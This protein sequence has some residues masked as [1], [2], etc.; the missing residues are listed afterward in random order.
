VQRVTRLTSLVPCQN[1]SFAPCEFRRAPYR[2]AQDAA[3]EVAA[4]TGVPTV[5][6]SSSVLRPLDP[7]AKYIVNAR[8][9]HRW[10]GERLSLAPEPGGGIK[11][12]FRYD[13]TT[14]SN[15]GRPLIFHYHVT[16]GPREDGYPLR[17]MRC[18]PAPG[19]EGHRSMCLYLS[20][21][22]MLR[23][24]I[25]EEKPLL[26]KPLNKIIGWSRPVTGAGCYCEPGS[27][28]HKW[29]LALETIHFALLQR[30]NALRQS[31]KSTPAINEV[32][33][34]DSRPTTKE[35]P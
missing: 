11:A 8:A 25:E 13:G 14:C 5:Q 34:E 20:Q 33:P 32:P 26:G 1:C 29:G 31:D 28:Q 30:E 19:D 22:E 16:L 35:F 15:M 24:A 7:H 17:E 23:K 2:R 4:A 10:A 9:L 12:L 3:L 18:S 27:R 6:A 21:P